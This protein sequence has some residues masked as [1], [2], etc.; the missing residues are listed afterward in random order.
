MVRESFFGLRLSAEIKAALQRA[1]A[2]D[3]RTMSSLVEKILAEWLETNG[4]AKPPQVKRTRGR[5]HK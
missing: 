4:Y 3:R 1:A 2:D 5:Q